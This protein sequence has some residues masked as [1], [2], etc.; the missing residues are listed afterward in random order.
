MTSS[1]RYV[2]YNFTFMKIKAD[3]NFRSGTFSV[4]SVWALC[5][6]TTTVSAVLASPTMPSH[7]AQDPGI[8]W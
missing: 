1:A 7:Y 3:H 8:Q 6:D 4:V 5:K 2:A